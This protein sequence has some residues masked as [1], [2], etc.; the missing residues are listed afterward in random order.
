[1]NIYAAQ[2]H[3]HTFISRAD[4][5][6]HKDNTGQRRVDKPVT[7]AFVQSAAERRASKGRRAEAL[8][9]V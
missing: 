1:M 5:S 6:G 3:I 9:L 2:I 8:R 7:A 4:N